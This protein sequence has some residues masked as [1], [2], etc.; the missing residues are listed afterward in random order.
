M[1]SE[2]IINLNALNVLFKNEVKRL[3]EVEVEN[4]KKEISKNYYFDDCLMSREDVAEKLNVSI[5]TIDNLR[6][7]NRL[8]AGIKL[9]HCADKFFETF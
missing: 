4:F 8:H 1:D 5:G 6:N 3:V 2:N 7:R 9:F